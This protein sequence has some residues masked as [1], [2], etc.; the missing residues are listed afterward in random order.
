MTSRF[1]REGYPFQCSNYSVNRSNGVFFVPCDTNTG[2]PS[3]DSLLVHY[4]PAPVLDIAVHTV[5]SHLTEGPVSRIYVSIDTGFYAE[6]DAAGTPISTRDPEMNDVANGVPRDQ[7]TSGIATDI[8]EAGGR[9]HG[10][11]LLEWRGGDMVITFI[12]R[13]LFMSG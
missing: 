11:H 12:F 8:R 10:I 4:L 6:E 7:T 2:L 5:K 3:Q 1:P 9:E 13:L